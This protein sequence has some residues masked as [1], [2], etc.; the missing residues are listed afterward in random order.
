M[1]LIFNESRLVKHIV[2][3]YS[4]VCVQTTVDGFRNP[5]PVDMENIPCFIGFRMQ[6][7]GAGFLNHQQYELH[8]GNSSSNIC[9]R[10]QGR[11]LQSTGGPRHRTSSSWPDA[12]AFD[13]AKRHLVA[14]R[15]QPTSLVQ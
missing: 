7:G 3:I 10:C 13:D 15:P 5:A 6:Q 11:L 4:V 12:L 8:T 2:G 1:F 14:F 9:V